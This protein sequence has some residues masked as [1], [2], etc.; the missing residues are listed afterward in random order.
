MSTMNCVHLREI[1]ND[2]IYAETG[3]KN[4]RTNDCPIRKGNRHMDNHHMGNHH[5]GNR[6]MAWITKQTS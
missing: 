3:A 4:R 2:F 5:M 6:N 1:F